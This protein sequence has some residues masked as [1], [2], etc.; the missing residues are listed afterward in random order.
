MEAHNA[1]A[2]LLAVSPMRSHELLP[3]LRP[4]RY[5]GV[6]IMDFISLSEEL[7]GEIPLAHI[8]DE[9][10]MTAALNSSVVRIRKVKRAMDV[11]V[12]LIGLIPGIPLILLSGLLIRLTSPGPSFIAKGGGL[13]VVRMSCS[14][15]DMRTDAGRAARFGRGPLIAV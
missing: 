10:L 15:C 12:S 9:W 6:E 3:H 4:L 11:F 5:A 14:N 7:A 8:N 2:I 13:A 1:S